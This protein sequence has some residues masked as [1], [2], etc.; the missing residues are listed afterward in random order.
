[1]TEPRNVKMTKVTVPVKMPFWAILT[2]SSF[3]NRSVMTTKIGA[4]PK[5]FTSVNNVERQKIRN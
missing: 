4:I 1:M 3:E 5:G 2:R